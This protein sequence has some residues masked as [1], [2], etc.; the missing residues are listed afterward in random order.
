MHRPVCVECRA[1]SPDLGNGFTTIASASPATGWRLSRV[2]NADGSYT[3][4]WRCPTCWR[5][6]RA[7]AQRERSRGG[8]TGTRRS[9][10]PRRP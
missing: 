2:R 9:L 8:V 6:L 1:A 7:A 3:V 10:A 4:E 5:K